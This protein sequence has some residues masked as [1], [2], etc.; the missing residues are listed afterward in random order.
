MPIFENTP[1]GAE[2]EPFVTHHNALNRDFFLRISLEL[3]L[4]KMLVAGYEKVFEIGRIFRNEGIDAEHLQDYTQVEFYWAYADFDQ[5]MDFTREMYQFVIKQ[6]FGT[7]KFKHNGQTIDW[8]GKW[9]VFDY[10]ELFEKYTGLDVLKASEDELKKYAQEHKITYEKFA[11]RSRLIDLIFKK[12]IRTLPEVSV[13]PAF[14]V[15]PPIEIE[16]LAKKNPLDP[17][18]VQRMQILAFGTELGK[19]FGELNDPIDQR[20]RFEEQMK[21]REGGD[22]EA[23]MIDEDYIEAME[24]GMPPSIGFGVSERLFS[25]LLGL[26]IRE[27]IIFPLMKE[28]KNEPR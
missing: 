18:T 14:L 23:Q 10:A 13:Q 7:L 21:L 25:V 26:P 28:E 11:H 1:G 27:T 2:A 20:E 22:K 8:S 16:P 9:K 24:Y 19:G 4:K 6:T 5:L 12:K 3:P 17:R 15:N